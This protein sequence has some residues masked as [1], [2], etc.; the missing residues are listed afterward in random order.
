MRSKGAALLAAAA[1]LLLA[2]PARAAGDQVV[3]VL[4]SE[5]GAYMEAFSAFQAEYGG[6]VRRFD[7]S[8]GKVTVPPGTGT[9]VTFGT[10]AM[11]Q[12][13]P[14][15]ANVVS[16]LAPGYFIAQEGRAGSAVKISM[17]P[18]FPRLIAEI[19]RIQP[20][21]KRLRV[22]WKVESYAAFRSALTAAGEEAGV[23]I[24]P[25]KV[26]GIDEL[27]ALLREARGEMDAFF[28]PPDPFLISP[29]SLMIFKEFSWSNAI[30]MYASTKGIAKEG[31]AASIGISFAEGGMAAARAAKGLQAGTPQPAVLFPE[32]M[33]LSLNATAARKCGLELPPELIREAAYLFP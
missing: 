14:A 31:A 32:K 13:Y 5:G 11:A 30:P 33:E 18:A 29:E 21:L 10:K 3:A 12:Q 28:L 6:E 15:D 4:A 8:R 1:A 17:L 2:G 25:V 23:L 24:T 26:S 16:C 9:I 27:P 20:K 22:F 7:S 19:R